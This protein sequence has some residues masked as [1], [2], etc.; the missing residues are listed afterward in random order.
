L[1]PA[2]PDGDHIVLRA[3]TCDRIKYDVSRSVELIFGCTTEAA[4]VH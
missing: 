2:P 1:L 3:D 4:V